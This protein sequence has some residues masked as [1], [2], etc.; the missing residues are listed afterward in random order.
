MI[1][2]E[3]NKGRSLLDFW[4]QFTP[5]F[6][7]WWKGFEETMFNFKMRNITYVPGKERSEKLE[8]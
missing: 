8:N 6:D 5:F 1:L 2:P 4:V 7:D 3:N